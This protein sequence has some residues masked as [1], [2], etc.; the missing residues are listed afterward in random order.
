[1]NELIRLVMAY[2]DYRDALDCDAFACEDRDTAAEFR[3]GLVACAAALYATPEASW[4]RAECHSW[5]MFFRL[6]MRALGVAK[7]SAPREEKRVADSEVDASILAVLENAHP[8]PVPVWRM[9]QRLAQLDWGSSQ[10]PSEEKVFSRI[11]ALQKASGQVVR[12]GGDVTLVVPKSTPFKLELTPSDAEKKNLCRL[13]ELLLASKIVSG[14]KYKTVE[15]IAV[16]AI[17]RGVMTEE[18]GVENVQK[19]MEVLNL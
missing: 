5:Q 3:Q 16:D 15:E 14:N 7:K 2:R 1:M 11:E 9:C 17:H 6:A 8:V 19:I 10:P 12:V 13:G 4:V 18:E